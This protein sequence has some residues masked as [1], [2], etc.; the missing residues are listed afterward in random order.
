MTFCWLSDPL[1]TLELAHDSFLAPGGLLVVGGVQMLTRQAE[2]I[3]DQ[4]FLSSLRDRLRAEGRRVDVFADAGQPWHSWVLLRKGGGDGDG[5]GGDCTSGDGGDAT[6]AP[7]QQDVHELALG[8]WLS[9][10]EREEGGNKCTYAITLPMGVE[11]EPFR[12]PDE[13]TVMSM[14]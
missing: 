13:L 2:V 12:T 6:G 5:H 10:D 8:R 1:G 11:L 3:E 9:Y 14:A 7:Q 4:R